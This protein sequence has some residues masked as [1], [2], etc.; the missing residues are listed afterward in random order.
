MLADSC[1]VGGGPSFEIVEGS[2]AAVAAVEWLVVRGTSGASGMIL[3]TLHLDSSLVPKLGFDFD[4]VV[5]NPVT[6]RFVAFL[7]PRGGF[8]DN[9]PNS[10]RP[11]LAFFERF[12]RR[13]F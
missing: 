4:F 2:A 3:H 10:V 5:A 12:C 9:F 7:F 11:C 1:S 8:V 6:L 13:V